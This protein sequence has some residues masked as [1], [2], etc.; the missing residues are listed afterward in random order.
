MKKAILALS[1][2]ILAASVY[3]MQ[4]SQEDLAKKR[5]EKLEKEFLK[6]SSWITDYTAAKEESKKTGKP[7]FAY[8]TRSY[9]N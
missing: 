3:A 4:P 2:T 6:K 7:I 9:A 5:D 8:F 1:L